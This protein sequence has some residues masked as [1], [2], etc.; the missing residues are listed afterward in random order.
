MAEKLLPYEL[1]YFAADTGKEGNEAGQGSTQGQQA[2]G[3]QPSGT[4][5]PAFDYDKLANIISGRQSVAEDTVLKNFFKQQGM[6]K[7]EMDQA[8]NSFKEEKARNQ[9]DVEG[10]RI[11]AAEAQKMA[12]QAEVEKEAVLEAMALG[13]EANTIPYL[14]RLADL[15]AVVGEDGKVNKEELKKALNGVL[16]DVPQLKPQKEENKGFQ[17]GSGGNAGQ[18]QTTDDVLKKAFGL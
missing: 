13:L 16:E 2:S 8:I 18:N 3:Q 14:I 6:S 15:S 12:R 5:A 1:Q 4:T 11:Q 9:P 10:L 17:I 7:E